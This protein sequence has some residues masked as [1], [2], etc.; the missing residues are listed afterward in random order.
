VELPFGQQELPDNSNC[1]N[2]SFH[3]QLGMSWLPTAPS[4]IITCGKDVRSV[5]DLCLEL[6]FGQQEAA[7]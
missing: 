5:H 3:V 1:K 2:R 6:P 7:S 4:G